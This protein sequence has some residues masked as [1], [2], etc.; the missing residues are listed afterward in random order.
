MKLLSNKLIELK[1]DD[2]IKIENLEREN[3]KL[4]KEK[5]DLL[6]RYKFYLNPEE[7]LISV[8]FTNKND[9]FQHSFICKNTDKFVDV[10]AKFYDKE[11][12]LE[13]NKSNNVF[14]VGNSKIDKS[15][16]LNQLNIIDSS[17]IILVN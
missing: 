4:Q 9:D 17:T 16:N 15:K 2:K 5:E 12:A 14:I 8:V 13:G 10:E 1:N 11:P 7:K 3:Q 6:S